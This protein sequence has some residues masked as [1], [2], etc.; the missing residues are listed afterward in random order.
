M[1]LALLFYR[2][3]KHQFKAANDTAEKAMGLLF[4]RLGG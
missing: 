3:V 4:L 1:G 2:A